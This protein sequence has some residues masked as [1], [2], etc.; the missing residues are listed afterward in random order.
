MKLLNIIN[1]SV[2][3]LLCSAAITYLV[4]GEHGFFAYK[5]TQQEL[6][7]KYREIALLKQEIQKLDTSVLAWDNNDYEKETHARTTLCMSGTHE[8]VYLIKPKT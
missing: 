1:I 2:L 5:K 6:Q 3:L 7:Q 4:Y 8:L